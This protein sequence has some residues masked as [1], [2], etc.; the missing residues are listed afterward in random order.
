MRQRTKKARNRGT[1]RDRG[2]F[3]PQRSVARDEKKRERT[4]KK[5]TRVF[6]PENK[7]RVGS[8]PPPPATQKCGPASARKKKKKE[9]KKILNRKKKTTEDSSLKKKKEENQAGN[10]G[11]GAPTGNAENVSAGCSG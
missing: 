6:R 3:G 1:D 4:A 9:E 10:L 11:A 7:K 2:A 5:P 8:I